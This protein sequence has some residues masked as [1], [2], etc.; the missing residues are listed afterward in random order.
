MLTWFKALPFVVK[1]ILVIPLVLLASGVTAM[2][3][4]FSDG[5]FTNGPGTGPAGYGLPDVPGA[6]AAGDP[7]TAPP[8]PHKVTVVRPPASAPAVAHNTPLS[9]VSQYYTLINGGH[10]DMAWTYLSPAV[11]AQLG[12]F[13]SWA[14]G[15][16]GSAATTLVEPIRTSGDQLTADLAVGSVTYQ[17]TWTTNSDVSLIT[18]AHIVQVSPAAS[19]SAGP[20]PR[21]VGFSGDSTNIFTVTSWSGWGS[22][23]A[24]ATGTVLY[25]NCVPDCARSTIS[26]PYPATVTFSGLSG[27]KY[28]SVTEHILAGPMSG[29]QPGYPSPGD[30]NNETIVTPTWPYLVY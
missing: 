7:T 9:L 26:Q 18:S 19:P 24:T 8:K 5:F 25:L 11:Q 6:A 4:M 17:G 23:T 15:Y 3:V 21:I 14:D 2:G 12:P 1:L 10:F 22:D 13:A 20:E 28:T 29:M 30:P 27:G 16:S